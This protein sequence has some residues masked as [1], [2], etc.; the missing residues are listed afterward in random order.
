MPATTLVLLFLSFLCKTWSSFVASF[1]FLLH[2]LELIYVQC[3]PM[4]PSIQSIPG[5]VDNLLEN[6]SSSIFHLQILHLHLQHTLPC[7]AVLC[8][9]IC[10][11]RESQW[12]SKPTTP[13][14]RAKLEAPSTP[15]D[16]PN[17]CACHV[18][19]PD[20]PLRLHLIL[21]S[22]PQ[23]S[24]APL[25]Q[26]MTWR[27]TAKRPSYLHNSSQTLHRQPT[28]SA[29]HTPTGHTPSHLDT[30]H[31]HLNHPPSHHQNLTSPPPIYIPPEPPKW[32]TAAPNPP[33]P[34]SPPRAAPSARPPPA[35]PPS[36][37]PP[38]PPPAARSKP[39]RRESAV[40]RGLSEGPPPPPPPPPRQ[41]QQYQPKRRGKRPL[42]LPR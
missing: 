27:L 32:E 6:Y 19:Q 31:Q 24:S 11:S 1:P 17:A 9:C 13:S 26:P 3:P 2:N 16:P 40:P 29:I 30:S 35:P 28:P 18:P 23:P 37:S 42:P 10:H 34:P 41:E 12:G 21:N 33:P 7:H 8:A 15:W 25:A 5:L 4:G 20:G 14:T 39:H 36:A 38:P 22:S